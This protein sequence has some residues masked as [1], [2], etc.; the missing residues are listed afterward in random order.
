MPLALAALAARFSLNATLHATSAALLADGAPRGVP[1]AQLGAAGGAAVGAQ[2]WAPEDAAALLRGGALTA[3]GGAGGSGALP[4]T[5]WAGIVGGGGEPVALAAEL[6]AIT[7]AGA[8]LGCG[9]PLGDGSWWL[10]LPSALTAGVTDGSGAAPTGVTVTLTAAAWSLV[11]A[12]AAGVYGAGGA[13]TAPPAA[14]TPL[15]TVALSGAALMSAAVPPNTLLPGYLY[16]PA[17]T[18]RATLSWSFQA[19]AAP[20]AAPVL[21]PLPAG[22]AP[23]GSKIAATDS[24]PGVAIASAYAP[25]LLAHAQPTGGALAV[26]PASG[27]ALSTPFCPPHFP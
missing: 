21:P 20:W 8:A 6:W 13:S 1:A 17:V 23:P 3:P 5:L 24:S 15:H 18:F 22:F 9:V 16:R 11:G 26:S 19:A 25:L 4:S 7:P 12:P 10:P 27:T 2:A 14:A